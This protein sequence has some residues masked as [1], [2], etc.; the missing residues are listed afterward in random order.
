ME[1]NI[2]SI[3]KAI[4][5]ANSVIDKKAVDPVIIEVIKESDVADY[6]VICSASSDRGVKTLAENVA[7][8]LQENN[9]EIIGIEGIIK[10]NWILIDTSDV[11]THIF[12]NPMREFYDLEGLYIDSPK[13]DTDSQ[14]EL[15][16]SSS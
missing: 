5:I 7:K 10:R 13:I 1:T 12:Y 3:D 9:I 2:E 14:S 15:K 11:I 16:R 6:F 4:L 8:T